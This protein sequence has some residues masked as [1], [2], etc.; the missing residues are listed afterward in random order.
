MGAFLWMKVPRKLTTVSEVKRNCEPMNKNRI[1]R[2]RAGRV[3]TVSAAE[4]TRVAVLT[5]TPMTVL[6]DYLI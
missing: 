6:A 4:L 3:A 2:C 5:G 1:G